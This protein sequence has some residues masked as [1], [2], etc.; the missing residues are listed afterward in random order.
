MQS[1]SIFFNMITSAALFVRYFT[2]PM[3]ILIVTAALFAALPNALSLD[4]E[5][6]VPSAWTGSSDV[7]VEPQ[8]KTSDNRLSEASTVRFDPICRG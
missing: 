5:S 6:Y 8:D 3:F 2:V 7:C 4:N 1:E